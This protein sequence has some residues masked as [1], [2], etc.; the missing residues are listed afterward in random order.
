VLTIAPNP[1]TGLWL[2]LA[3][4][5]LIVVVKLGIQVTAYNE[6]AIQQHQATIKTIPSLLRFLWRMRRRQIRIL[7]GVSSVIALTSAFVTIFDADPWP[8]K[9][10][11]RAKD[12]VSESSLAPDFT[13][14][15]KSKYFSINDADMTCG[16]DSMVFSDLNGK[17]FGGGGMAF[18]TGKISIPADSSYNYPCDAMVT[19]QYAM[20]GRIRSATH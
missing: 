3:V 15:N 13:L 6:K 9:P 16:I 10:F 8:T 7:V 19:C 2:V 17:I 14:I 20:T 11:V 4:V 12:V 18:H 1:W 5:S